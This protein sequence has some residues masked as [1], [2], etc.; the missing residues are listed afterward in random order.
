MAGREY[1]MK[2]LVCF[3]VAL[4]LVG[5]LAGCGGKGEAVSDVLPT[6]S[7]SSGTSFD[8][9]LLQECAGIASK[10]A[11]NY[12]E[13]GG[14]MS[15][16]RVADAE[17]GDNAAIIY[18]VE[19]ANAEPPVSGLIAVDTVDKS[20]Y[21]SPNTTLEGPIF[22]RMTLNEETGKYEVGS[23]L[24]GIRNIVAK[25]GTPVAQQNDTSYS[26]GREG[27]L[28]LRD[29]TWADWNTI[30]KEDFS[31]ADIYAQDLLSFFSEADIAVPGTYASWQSM[32]AALQENV[33]ADDA[34]VFHTACQLMEYDPEVC[35]R[36][37]TV[38][39]GEPE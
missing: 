37:I 2:K 16:Y 3:M 1:I 18:R 39:V 4:L 30:T 9:A 33:G 23:E 21:F 31:Y 25:G 5:T 11:N 14:K 29:T 10:A 6:E 38:Q 17:N 13:P 15:L 19:I 32:A 36:Y 22:N 34:L 27:L 26:I 24:S 20:V 7:A 8:S 12:F 28:K 35:Y